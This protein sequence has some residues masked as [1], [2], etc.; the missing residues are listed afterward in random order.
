MIR[1]LVFGA[2]VNEP[3]KEISEEEA[4]LK[5]AEALKRVAAIYAR[6]A[7]IRSGATIQGGK[8]TGDATATP[9]PVNETI[10][11]IDTAL[12]KLP[13]V[14]AVYLCLKQ[15]QRP[16]TAQQIWVMLDQSG[17]QVE[18]SDPVL[19][20]RWALNKL[21]TREADVFQPGWGKW[22]LKSRYSQRRLAKMLAATAGKGGRS[23]DEHVKRTKDGMAKALAGGKRLG[24]KP[25]VTAEHMEKI[26]NALQQGTRKSKAAKAAGVPL[27]TYNYYCSRYDVEN[28]KPGDAWPPPL[29]QTSDPS[30][31]QGDANVFRLKF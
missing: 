30:K 31:P 22:H 21:V 19:S 24:R 17:H 8:G 16:L 3:D 4:L 12:A 20:V 14:D 29:K 23:K 18:A 2:V 6:I 10:P 13:I 15:S 26:Y 28:W 11:L 25:S 27:T 9:E 1:L 7:T 5:E